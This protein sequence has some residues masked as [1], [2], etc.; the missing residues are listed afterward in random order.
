MM[1]AAVSGAGYGAAGELFYRGSPILG[2]R[3]PG[4]ALLRITSNI[5]DITTLSRVPLIHEF[6]DPV[7]VARQD[8]ARPAAPASTGTVTL[9]GAS[10]KRMVKM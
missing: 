9:L 6:P 7:R 10:G 4:R 5:F 3:C 1:R 2:L 8:Y